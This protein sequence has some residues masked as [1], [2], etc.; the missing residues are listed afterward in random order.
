MLLVGL[1]NTALQVVEAN[2]QINLGSTYRKFCKKC[3]G[4]K[5]FEINPFSISLQQPG[6]YHILI[7]A[8]VSAEAAGDIVLNLTENGEIVSTV[9]ETITTPTTEFRNVT[10]HYFFLVDSSCLL[11]NRVTDFKQISLVNAGIEAT[12]EN[13][14]TD[15]IKVVY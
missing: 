8:T 15:V 7:T 10:L 3:N 6:I 2:S 11:G 14:V 13:I 5:A 9:T 4:I 12:I 1:K